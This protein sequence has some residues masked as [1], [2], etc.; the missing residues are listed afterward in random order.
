MAHFYT[1]QTYVDASTQLDKA[2][3]WLKSLGVIYSVTRVGRYKTLFS[4]LAKYQL[5]NDLDGFFEEYKFEDWVNA[6]HEVAELV[7]MYEGLNGQTDPSLVIRLQDSLKGHEL[8]VLDNKDRSGRDFSLE[9]SI[10]AK[11]AHRGY[12]INFGHEAD[13]EVQIA[14]HTFYVECKRLKSAHQVKK[15]IKDGLS[16]LHKRYVKS[17]EPAT[18]RGL[19]VLSI[20]KTINSKLGLLEGIDPESL[21]N[22]AFAYNAVFIERYRSYWQENVDRRTLGV[23]VVLDTPG[24][25]KPEKK[26]VTSHEVTMNNCIPADTQ[27]YKLLLR[28]AGEVFANRTPSGAGF[29]TP[30]ITF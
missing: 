8:F 21:S 19:L 29:A 5:A 12:E 16:Q 22:K 2:C 11:F 7:R 18:A 4:S 24:M 17:S 3:E 27:D 20:G 28:V 1:S 10:A 30:L 26:L 9:L 14:E 15:R 23:A 13:L 6:A 25:L